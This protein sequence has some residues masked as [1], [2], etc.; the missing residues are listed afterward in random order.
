LSIKPQYAEAIFRGEKRFEFRRSVFRKPVDVVVIYI[1]SPVCSVAGEFEVQEIIC[2]TVDRLWS[3]TQTKAGIH[4]DVFFDYFVGRQM[5]YAI[6]IGNVRRYRKPL[7]LLSSFGI[8]PPQS[9][10]YV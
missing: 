9:F 5:G 6:S 7:D 1:T 4:R 10:V 8:R 3:R 2:D